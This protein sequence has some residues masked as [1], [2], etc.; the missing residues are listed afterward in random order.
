MREIDLL[1]VGG[2][3]AGVAAAQD[4]AAR[5]ARALVI[6][7]QPRERL[8]AL[9]G[10]PPGAQVLTDHSVWGVFPAEPLPTDDGMTVG[11]FDRQRA[12][13]FLA[14]A[15]ELVLAT[16]GIDVDLAFHGS[17]LPGV[18]SGLAALRTSID[19]RRMVVLGS[20]ALAREVARRA[21]QM[22][23]DVVAMVG[24]GANEVGVPA[25]PRHRVRAA[26]GAGRLERVILATSDDESEDISVEADALCIAIGRQ[27]A[28]ELAYLA[29]CPIDYD[30]R[31]GGFVPRSIPGVTVTGDLAGTSD[32][33][34]PSWHRVADRVATDDTVM[35]ACEGVTR[36]QIL[37]ALPH[38]FGHPDEIKRLTRAGMG[39]CQ[40]RGCRMSIAS[41]MA[42]HLGVPLGDIPVASFRPPVR[43]LPLSALASEDAPPAP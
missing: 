25:Y 41:L 28:I 27:P 32:V 36:G 38:A 34:D 9:D 19:T 5:G 33:A 17:D 10:L 22:D 2:G 8:A 14:R 6:D 24:F 26:R 16:G 21:R 13:T 11:I 15:H 23:V 3:P 31:R 12:R 35:C 4:F 1:I 37:G 39:E 18:A 29:G 42:L 7:E 40:G 43:L 20:G 30:A